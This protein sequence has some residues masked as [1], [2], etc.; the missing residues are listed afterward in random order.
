MG[1]GAGDWALTGSRVRYGGFREWST[2]EATRVLARAG[3]QGGADAVRASVAYVDYDARNPGALAD[4]A[5]TAAPERAFANNVRQ[6]TGEAG[7]HG[8]LGL[9]WRREAGAHA[10]EASA[11]ALARTLDN[12]IPVRIVVLDRRAGGVRGAYTLSTPGA[13]PRDG[14]APGAPALR[15]TVGGEL[16][17]QRDDRQNFANA[18]GARGPRQLDQ[19][20]RVGTAAAFAQGTA[21]LGARTT[22]LAGLRADRVRFAAEDRLV[23]ATN[24]DD[25]G[26]RTMHA[27]S[28]SVGVSVEVAP[29][30]AFY[31]NAA[32]AFETPTTTELANRPTEAGGFNPALSPQRARSVE[33][34][35]NGAR[36]IGTR[37]ALSWQLAAYHTRLTD[38]LVP[39]E[40]PDAPGRQFF[41]NAGQATHRGVEAGTALLVGSV[42]TVRAAYTLTDA[43]F[44]RYAVGAASFAGRRVPGVAPERLDLA[45]L[46]RGP[47]GA[48]VEL[49]QRTQSWTPAD[50]A[51]R[52]RSPGWSVATV[53]GVAPELRLAGVRVAPF[54]GVANLFGRRWDAAVTVNA[55][56]QRYYEPG[57]GRTVY[58]GTD[59]VGLAGGRR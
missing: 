12:P 37:L 59:L 39:F 9:Q 49:E 55:A 3:W 7:R 46:V 26:E 22:L 47:R 5:R 57:P 18:L 31:A 19:L 23:S 42:A 24:P 43:R 38:A 51:N 15:L 52:A 40:V 6:R 8:Q 21:A 58:L 41:R 2:Q 20:E 25:S 44:D 50:D 17:Q 33:A 10:L 34:G 53:R 29:G 54:A 30:V 35:M 45:V 14:G 11:F 48:F 28:P 16:Q 56:G 13:L 4:S 32:T 1:A 27:V 36:P